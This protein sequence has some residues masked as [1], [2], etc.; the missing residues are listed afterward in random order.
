MLSTLN[1]TTHPRS[2]GILSLITRSL[3]NDIDLHARKPKVSL[4]TS[5]SKTGA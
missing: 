5:L 4:S 3:K 1:R 2:I